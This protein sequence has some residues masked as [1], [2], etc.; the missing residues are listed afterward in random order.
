MSG[1]IHILSSLTHNPHPWDGDI[2]GRINLNN[3][4]FSLCR[5]AEA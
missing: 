5:T 3:A 4:L 2:L 1:S